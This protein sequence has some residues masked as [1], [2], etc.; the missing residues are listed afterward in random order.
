MIKNSSVMIP[1]ML[2]RMLI[3]TAVVGAGVPPVPSPEFGELLELDGA[4]SVPVPFVFDSCVESTYCILAATGPL[5]VP[6][7]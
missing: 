6:L 7:T 1:V 4:E 5:D 2:Y 3:A